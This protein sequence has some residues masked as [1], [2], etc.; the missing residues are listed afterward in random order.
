MLKTIKRFLRPAAKKRTARGQKWPGHSES[1]I[2]SLPPKA[3]DLALTRKDVIPVQTHIGG[4]CDALD[5]LPLY[6]DDKSLFQDALR[7]QIAQDARTDPDVAILA[8]AYHLIEPPSEQ[9]EAY[10]DQ[11][12]AKELAALMERF[13][14]NQ[15]SAIAD[16]GC[17][18]GWIALA[19]DRL[20]YKNLTA[21]DPS[22][23]A[24]ACLRESKDHQIEVITDLQK[25]R[26]IRNRFDALVSLATVHHWQH[27]PWISLEAR[28]TMKP[29]A[30]WFAAMEQFADTP[31]EFLQALTTHPTRERYECY[32]W[33]YP[34]SAYVDLIQSVGFQL[35]SVIPQGY[36][37]NA[38]LS[39]SDGSPTHNLDQEAFD[40]FVDEHLTGP[41]G[42]V[43][44][45]WAEVDLQRRKPGRRRQF[46]R[47]QVMI[48][49]RQ[50]LAP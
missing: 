6:D 14:I 11:G 5:N 20:G 43:E 30:Y 40:A 24:T 34:V 2:R 39:V 33:A 18:L 44:L 42:A 23:H 4:A 13:G 19:L 8:D 36:K 1:S 28:R 46:T 48:F 27:I 3:I 31:A 25:W 22:E 35:V 38:Y 16:V 49:Q 37:Q 29:G 7:T 32:E 41:N 50:G 26:S 12:S 10:I 21:M 47:P 17:G 45:F 15:D 9:I